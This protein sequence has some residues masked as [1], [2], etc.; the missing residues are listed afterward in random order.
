MHGAKN[1]NV[2]TIESILMGSITAWIGNSTMQVQVQVRSPE[3]GVISCVHLQQAIVDQ[4]QED[5][6]EHQPTKQWTCLSVAIREVFPLP[7]AFGLLRQHT[8]HLLHY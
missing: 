7:E 4:G 5:S 1:V 3:G 8:Q 6:E 2:C